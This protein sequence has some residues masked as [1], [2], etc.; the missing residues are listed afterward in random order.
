LPKSLVYLRCKRSP[1]QL[2][3]AKKSLGQ[4]FLTD[5]RVAQRIVD[6]A[7]PLRTDIV[8]E[9]GPGTGAL[10]RLL[11]ERSSVVEAIELDERLAVVLRRAV[12][13]T[14][15][16][17]RV[18]DA[19]TID[20]SDL[21]SSARNKLE[22]P[23]RDKSRVRVIANLPYYISTPI[24]EKLLSLRRSVFDMTLM[25]QKEVADRIT[26]GPGG[27]EYGALSVIVQYQC[28][29]S[30]LFDVGPS[31]FTPAPKVHSAVVHLTVREQPPV[32]VRDEAQ[33]FSVVRAAFAQR[34]KTIL[35]NLKAAA[36]VSKFVRPL[37]EALE[38]A[39]VS[40][41]RRAETLTVGEF[42]LL[43]KALCDQTA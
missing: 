29:A 23:D 17:I 4:N 34:R 9:I 2:I 13:A 37:E 1:E 25:L 11:V 10:T 31:A 14:N 18:A 28:V 3:K 7:N 30:K 42:A 16:E 20:W 8:I 15:L 5:H 36:A 35:N 19:L 41:Q 38:A 12:P 32:E 27:K 43:T 22:V 33:F 6:A 26:E 21:I 39:S 24:L 40:P